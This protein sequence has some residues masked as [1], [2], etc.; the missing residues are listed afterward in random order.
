M[1]AEKIVQR[2]NEEYK[3]F[4]YKFKPTHDNMFMEYEKKIIINLVTDK[5]FFMDDR[6][7]REKI[8]LWKTKGYTFLVFSFREF[9][10]RDFNFIHS[11]IRTNG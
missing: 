3:E 4:G 1:R 6:M 9:K 7:N 11:Q 2:F 8:R 10:E 5:D